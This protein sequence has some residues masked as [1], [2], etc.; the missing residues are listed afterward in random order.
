MWTWT[1][2]WGE[3]RHDLVIGSCPRHP[4][5]IDRISE[6][7][8]VGALLSL[9]TDDCR[10]ALSV[11]YRV[12]AEHA[13]HR[14]L[15]MVNAPM[16]DFDA[17][18]QRKRLP[19]A[20]RALCGLLAQGHR[21]YVHCTAGIN[22]APL[23]VL[24][25]L[26]LVEG[27]AVDDAMTLIHRGRPEASPYWDPYQGCRQDALAIVRDAVALRAWTLWQAD[28]SSPAEGNWLRAEAEV[29][30]ETFTR[31]AYSSG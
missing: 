13:E 16:R 1:L 2:N 28:P 22:R 29:L 10:A 25:Y 12:L 4:D 9:Q 7:T 3:V 15:V 27:M 18:D 26:T 14:G 11:D 19:A 21:T 6:K 23:A 5:D 30:R 24:T 17:E 8:R 31:Y 20:V